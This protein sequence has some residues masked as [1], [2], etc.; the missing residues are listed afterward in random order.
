MRVVSC[1]PPTLK[2]NLTFAGIKF[3]C[4]LDIN[5]QICPMF[6]LQF[7][8]SVR[9][10]R[11][12]NETLSITFIINNVEIC[13][14]IEEFSRILRVPCEGVCMFITDWAIFSVPN[15]IDSNP[16]IYPP[17]VEDPSIICDTLFYERPPG[18]TRKV[19]VQAIVLDP[20]QMVLSEL[21]L[22]FKK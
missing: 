3:D 18:K 12:L 1:T 17:P 2:T 15:N 13:L 21:K 14:R 10:I 19:K 16:D 8:K 9:L 6:V 20:F 4:V 22:D 5:K 11:N 7:Y